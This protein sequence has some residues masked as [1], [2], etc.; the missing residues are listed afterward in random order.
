MFGVGIVCGP[1]VGG[2]FA[3][4]SATWRWGFYLNLVVGGIFAPVYLF[5]LPNFDPKFGQENLLTRFQS[6]DYVGALL[7]IGTLVSVIMAINFGGTLYA[8]NSGQVIALFVVAAVLVTVFALQQR[9]SVWTNE[10]ERMFPVH[11]LA[12]K[13]AV[14]LFV[15]NSASNAGGY[16]PLYYIPLFFQFTRG[17]DALKAAVRLLPLV[18]VY[19]FTV[20]SNGLFMSKFGLYQPWFVVGSALLLIGG[21]VCC[22]CCSQASLEV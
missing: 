15:L 6:I 12:N 2:A 4:S 16:V 8:W 11:F 5:L 22:R 19:S 14:L 10:S 1:V 13:E 20:I 18:F 7:S 21:A 9:S 3:Q 17:D